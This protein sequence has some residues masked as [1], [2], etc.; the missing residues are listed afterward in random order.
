MYDINV[1]F[2]SPWKENMEWPL[3]VR[4]DVCS[5]TISFDTH[6][7]YISSSLNLI[8]WV[9]VCLPSLLQLLCKIL[10]K[11]LSQIELVTLAET[12][13]ILSVNQS[14]SVSE[15]GVF[16]IIWYHSHCLDRWRPE[17]QSFYVPCHRAY[18][19]LVVELEFM[20]IFYLYTMN[21]LK[22]YFQLLSPGTP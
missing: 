21:L 4:Y 15:L 2:N 3:W 22:D 16:A 10:Q 17:A 11:K 6:M 19:R 9:I 5:E 12:S 8:P 14:D 18:C 7:L 1:F 13:T 20:G